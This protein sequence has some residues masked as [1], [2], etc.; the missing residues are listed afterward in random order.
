[1]YNI[2][3]SVITHGGY[4]L[5]SLTRKIDT[6]WAEGKLTDAERETLL[7]SAQANADSAYSIDMAK[8]LNELEQRVKAL[9]N[10]TYPDAEETVGEF[11]EGKWYYNGDDCTFNDKT[12]KC[13]APDGVV[14]VWSP[15]AYPAY[16][17][18]V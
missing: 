11:V 2:I 15:A 5:T 8:K 13:I 1:M 4:D 18:E 14:C 10:K 7:N 3:T 9:E 16:W 6:L 17:E 12:Y